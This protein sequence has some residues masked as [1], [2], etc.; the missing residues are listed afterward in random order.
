MSEYRIERHDYDLTIRVHDRQ[1]RLIT[2]TQQEC[3]EH[4]IRGE[5]IEMTIARALYA[6]RSAALV[7]T[8]L[9]PL[10]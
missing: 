1:G 9:P 6:R 8:S 7:L 3:A 5:A 4:R 10:A 2:V